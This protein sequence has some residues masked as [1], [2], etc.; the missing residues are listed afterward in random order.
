MSELIRRM[1]SSRSGKALV[2]VLMIATLMLTH[3]AGHADDDATAAANISKGLQQFSDTLSQVGTLGQLAQAIPFVSN[4]ADGKPLLLGG[5]TGFDIAGFAAQLKAQIAAQVTSAT[6]QLN[7]TYTVTAGGGHVTFTV[8]SALQPHTAGQPYDLTL[9]ISA[10][11]TFTLPLTYANDIINING[12]SLTAHFTASSVFAFEYDPTQLDAGGDIGAA[13]YI[14]TGKS[15]PFT[16][17]FDISSPTGGFT[18]ADNFTVNLGILKVL[19]TGSVHLGASLNV[20][21][22]DSAHTG[23]I[24]RDQFK[25]TPLASLFVPSVPVPCYQMNLTLASAVAN[26]TVPGTATITLNPTACGTALVPTVDVGG[27]GDFTNMT[28]QDFLDGLAQLANALQSSQQSGVG[29]FSIP[30]LGQ[31]LS[32]LANFGQKIIDFLNSNC[33]TASALGSPGCPTTASATPG[34][35]YM[36]AQIGGSGSTSNLSLKLLPQYLQRV[37]N[38]DKIMALLTTAFGAY[39]GS[40]LNL[41]WDGANEKLKFQVHYCL[42]STGGH[43]SCDNL[44]VDPSKLTFNFGNQLESLGIVGLQANPTSSISISPYFHVDFG[45]G[46][47]LSRNSDPASPKSVLDRFELEPNPTAGQPEV[48]A[49]A[50]VTLTNLGLSGQLGFLNIA[51]TAPP[52]IALIGPKATGDMLQLKLNIPAG[53]SGIT[54]SQLFNTLSGPS[55]FSVFDTTNFPIVN[56]AGPNFTLGVSATLNG[57]SAPLATGNVTVAWPDILAGPP[58]ISADTS[59]DKL[60]DFDVSHATP[61]QMFG[62]VTNVLKVVATQLDSFASAD[63]SGSGI[64]TEKLP[65]IGLSLHEMLTQFSTISDE[66]DSLIANPAQ[67][68][69]DLVDRLSNDINNKIADQF[70][71]KTAVNKN[72]L[73]IELAGDPP[74]IIFHMNLGI[75]GEPDASTPANCNV[76]FPGLS[77][78]FNLPLPNLGGA[79][80]ES[81]SGA[82]ATATVDTTGP[83]VKIPVTNPGAGYTSAPAVTVAAPPS[84]STATATAVLDTVN[85]GQLLRIDVVSGGSGYTTPPAVTVAAPPTG[86]TPALASSV[87]KPNDVVTA[88][89]LV[90]GAGGAGFSTP[91]VVVFSGGNGTGAAATATISGSV[92]SVVVTNGG[93]GYSASSAV[94][95][96]GGGG[97]GATATASVDGAGKLTDIQVTA[98]GSGYT[99]PPTV[100]IAGGTGAVAQAT[101]SGGVTALSLTSGGSGYTS[102][103][104][105]SFEGGLA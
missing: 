93:A 27:L 1:L 9:T 100:A 87:I 90:A 38:I 103:P 47:D 82:Q 95:F 23:K 64:L 17:A 84:G 37:D 76:V 8:A 56:L 59:F 54:L 70:P 24:T 21:L 46:I 20:G 65:V 29:D 43:P 14:Q 12:G 66:V 63:S 74:A 72:F 22:S 18:A 15:Q 28:P 34:L 50:P 31:K 88:V 68:F 85:Q 75:C 10:D 105:I 53:Q 80:Q 19:I 45:V 5:P 67:S 30:F 35:G 104:T 25:N 32:D 11:S 83:V 33:L 78:P 57:A 3:S 81:G 16:V 39:G 55:P 77:L 61:A 99:S 96:S 26:L 6:L 86:G 73:T 58:T 7:H 2:V 94:S 44:P 69:Q 89:N 97:S 42:D 51:L 62:L 102:A 101:I 91:P 49:S 92:R 52:S 60:L 4:P 13:F 36:T 40:H 98:P 41:S 48:G 71:N 79:S